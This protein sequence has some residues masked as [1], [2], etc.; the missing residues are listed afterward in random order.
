MMRR[1]AGAGLALLLVAAL[2]PPARAMSIAPFRGHVG[3]GY[4]K[5]FATDAPGGSLSAAAGIDHPLYRGTRLGLDFGYHLLGSRNV[6]EG[7]LAAG[8]DYSAFTTALLVHWVPANLGP[9]GR[10][11]AGPALV[12]AHVDLSTSGGGAA[13]AKYAVDETAPGLALAATF[14]TKRETPVRTGLEVGATVGFLEDETWTLASL[15]LVFHY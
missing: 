8:L 2:T 12:N 14:I 6:E 15:R 10:L 4:A 5:L 7:S 9:V 1:A 3:I 11:S 13:F